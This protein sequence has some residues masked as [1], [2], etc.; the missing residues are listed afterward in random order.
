MH[1]RGMGAVE[2][3]GV[4]ERM[5]VVERDGRDA[6]QWMQWSAAP[7]WQATGRSLDCA[8]ARGSHRRLWSRNYFGHLMEAECSV[9]AG[10]GREIH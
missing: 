4:V 10:A 7:S 3:M 9:G 5:S 6:Q 2:R 8:R 1:W